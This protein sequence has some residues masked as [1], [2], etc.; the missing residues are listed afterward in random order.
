MSSRESPLSASFVPP[1]ETQRIR[2][3]RPK[4]ISRSAITESKHTISDC[5]ANHFSALGRRQNLSHLALLKLGLSRRMCGPISRPRHSLKRSSI[6]N[7]PS[8]TLA[9]QHRGSALLL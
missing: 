3:Q 8:K 7:Q 2:F 9:V 5:I 4:P 6:T 1:E